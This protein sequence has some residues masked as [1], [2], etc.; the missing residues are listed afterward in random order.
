M[1]LRLLFSCLIAVI[2]FVVPS[3]T[4]NETVTDKQSL[5][6]K[7]LKADS[8]I[9][10][11]QRFSIAETDNCKV[12]FIF[13][14]RDSKD[15]TATFVLYKGEQQPDLQFKNSY[16]INVPVKSIACLSSVY[17]SMLDKMN[18]LDK[19]VAIE[20][21]DYYNNTYILDK[22]RS[23]QIV[24]IAKSPEID[25]EKTLML[26]P[27]LLLTF[28]MGNPKDDVHEKILSSKIPVAV[29]LDHL[30]EHPLARAEWIKFIAAFFDKSTLADSLFLVTET[31]YTKL[32]SMTDSV[33]SKPSVLTEIK[34]ADAWYVPGGKSFMAHLLKDAG[35]NYLWK[36]ENQTGSIPLNFEQVYEKAG[37][38]DYWLNLFVNINTKKDLLAFDERYALFNAF[39]KGQLYN[40]TL[41]ANEKGYSIYWAEGM[42]NPDELLADLIAIFHPQLLPQ[43]QLK[44]YKKIN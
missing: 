4:Q 27:G 9:R 23:K 38:A 22:V 11:A 29:T 32:K 39:K 8:S 24:E 5:S 40:N 36:D 30:E 25:I 33:H 15:T 3:C 18:L 28:G 44:Y 13:G 12:L 6:A 2:V 35:A 37:G 17:A 10:Y 19:V 41:H 34:Y 14:K 7:S 31:N 20:N 26:N 16:Y 1:Y 43:H 42:T 21:A